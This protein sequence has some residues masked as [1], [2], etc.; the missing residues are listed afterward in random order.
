MAVNEIGT[1]FCGGLQQFVNQFAFFNQ[2][3][4][5]SVRIHQRRGVGVDPELMVQ[6]VEDVLQVHGPVFGHLAA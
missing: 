3:L 1:S 5:P 2:I 6:G 4:R